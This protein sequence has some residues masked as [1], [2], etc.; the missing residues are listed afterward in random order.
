M[1]KIYCEAVEEVK[2]VIE[3]I[4]FHNDDNGYSVMSCKTDMGKYITLTGNIA[5]PTPGITIKAEGVW[6]VH[7]K[8]GKQF[9]AEKCEEIAPDTVYGI[10][11]YLSSGLIKGIGEG[12]AKKIVDKFGTETIDVIENHP[13]RLKEVPRLGQKKIDALVESWKEQRHVMDIMIFLKSYD[14]S[15]LFAVK[16]Y[17]LYGNDA[18]EL[19]KENP[20]RL[21]TD[22]DGVGFK[23]ADAIAI[24]MGVKLDSSE[25]IA[26]GTKYTF[27]QLA[28]E[29][30][31]FQYKNFL[32]FDLFN[33]LQISEE[34]ITEEIDNMIENNDLICEDDKIFLPIYYYAEKN[35]ADKLLSIINSF[36]PM[37]KIS[38]NEITQIEQHIGIEYN[39]EQKDA[40]RTALYH[41]V[42]VLTGGPGTGKTTVTKGIITAFRLNHKSIL[43]AAPTGKA[44]DR[45]SEAT[46]TEAMTIHRLLGYVPEKG[47][48]YNEDNQLEGDIL[49]LDESSMINILLLNSLLKAVPMDMKIIF[50]GD[51]DQLPCIGPGNILL[52]MIKS[53]I[54][55]VV[56]LDKIFR[57]A[58][59]S[60]IITT[61]HDINHGII[62]QITN[63]KDTD[64]FFMT[65]Q[66]EEQ[67][68]SDIVDLVKNRLPKAYN[69]QPKDI[70]VLT[71]MKKGILGT[72][73]LNTVLQQELNPV[74]EEIKYGPVTFRVNDKVM[75]IKNNYDK[76]VF[77]GDSGYIESI[78]KE[79]RTVFVVF[80]KQ[81]IY[82][83]FSELD[84]LMLSYAVTVHKSQG[85]EYP[86]IIMPITMGHYIML[87]RN[88]LYT[89]ITRAKNMCVLI[90]QKPAFCTGIQTIDVTKRNTYLKEFLINNN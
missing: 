19:I 70:Q 30:N 4:L 84:E 67:I 74:G 22:M 44:A 42:M 24:K 45:M 63:M 60:K 9:V 18:I 48:R 72:M 43:C 64:L 21:I 15:T 39:D 23:K 32:I 5:S 56:R 65:R 11:K 26:A 90:G 13:E 59:K 40:I 71:P 83:D 14:I 10:F 62:P 35:V 69:I 73:Y 53:E 49:I 54:I 76:E 16:I 88:L 75:Q 68:L 61:A 87:K 41:N 12:F 6:K 78:D 38:D 80:K 89:G 8:Y 33:L 28:E 31:T 77:N 51:V 55:P 29:G 82:Y 81:S 58:A 37:N 52:D 27:N 57:Q 34:K 86:A 1:S 17:K 47:F 46:D 3:L 79:N 25:R 66:N 2:C 7:N 20:Y 85:S 36:K 50:I